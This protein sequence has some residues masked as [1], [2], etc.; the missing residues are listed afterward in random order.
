LI[1]ER[2][3]LYAADELDEAGRGDVQAHTQDCAAC[4]A[5]LEAEERLATLIE[6]VPPAAPDTYLLAS[7]RARLSDSLDQEEPGRLA[8]WFKVLLGPGNFGWRPAVTAALLVIVGFAAGR[9]APWQSYSQRIFGGRRPAQDLTGVQVANAAAM[10]GADVAGITWTPAA[11]NVLPNVQVQLESKEPV[12][13]QGTVNDDQV[14]DALLSVLRDSGRYQ[15]D[16]RMQSVELLRPRCGDDDVRQAMCVV[17]RTDQNPAVR[18][19]ALEALRGVR[20]TPGIQ[21]TLLETLREDSNP[22]VRVEAIN[23]LMALVNNGATF[24]AP[25][26]MQILRDS[27]R[28]DSNNYVRLQSAAILQN[29]DQASGHAVAYKPQR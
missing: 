21:Q 20:P 28:R 5:V 29:L 17:L 10:K 12:V 3:V 13:V 19:K 23:S 8:R 25:D 2:L 27:M 1:Q 7:C 22:G 15:P 24:A 14:K 4:A 6:S 26:D 11:D 16:V 9:V 18:L